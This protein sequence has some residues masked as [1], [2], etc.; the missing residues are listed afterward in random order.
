MALLQVRAGGKVEVL[1]WQDPEPAPALAPGR[2]WGICTAARAQE[3][4]QEPGAVSSASSVL[5]RE[6]FA[7]GLRLAATA[8]TISTGDEVNTSQ[9]VGAG[10]FACCGAVGSLPVPGPWLE[11]KLACLHGSPPPSH[12]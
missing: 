5:P 11:P 6:R 10:L 4:R 12:S 1:C 7:L 8:A 9:S 2:A 3:Q